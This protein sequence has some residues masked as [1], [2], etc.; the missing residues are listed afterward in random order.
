LHIGEPLHECGTDTNITGGSIHEILKKIIP[1]SEVAPRRISISRDHLL[2]DSITIFKAQDF[3][4]K[5]PVRVVFEGEP[6][7]DGGGPKREYFSLLLQSLVSPCCPIRLFEGRDSIVLPMHN[8]DALR[9]GMFKVAGRM[10]T[11]SVVNGGPGFPYLPSVLY[12]YFITPSGEIEKVLSEITK[13]DVVDWN[14]LEA[15]QKV[16]FYVWLYDYKNT[17]WSCTKC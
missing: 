6:A 12:S 4:Y 5:I 9:A 16:L 10:I 7:V 14:I 1:T 8:M 17:E 15:I 3:D 11:T 2:S 13:D